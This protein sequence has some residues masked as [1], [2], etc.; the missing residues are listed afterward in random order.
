[1]S[2]GR[3]IGF[4]VLGLFIGLV[5]GAAIGLGCG[6]AWITLAETS[7]FEGYSGFVVGFWI[8]GG[9]AVG[10][11]AGMLLLLRKA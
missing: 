11:L 4:G 5:A 7:S 3:K 9:A 10:A 6:L 1:M 2:L 8:L